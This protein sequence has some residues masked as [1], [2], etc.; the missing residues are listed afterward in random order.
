MLHLGIVPALLLLLSSLLLSELLC[1][2]SKQGST[3]KLRNQLHK[4][5]VGAEKQNPEGRRRWAGNEEVQVGERTP[6]VGWA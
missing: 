4:V 1:R 2:Y 6:R 5:E 3:T